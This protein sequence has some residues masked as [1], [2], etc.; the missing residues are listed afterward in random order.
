MKIENSPSKVDK[1]GKVIPEDL[2]LLAPE[3][4]ISVD[5]MEFSGRDYIIIKAKNSEFL[6]VM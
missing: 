2:T 4:Q 3:E 6:E 5:F 1:T